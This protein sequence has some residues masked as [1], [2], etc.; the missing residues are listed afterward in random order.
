MINGKKRKTLEKN[1]LN[2]NDLF[3]KFQNYLNE[4]LI[5]AEI[6]QNYK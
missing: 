4:P 6:I 5:F 3:Q 2:K 1:L